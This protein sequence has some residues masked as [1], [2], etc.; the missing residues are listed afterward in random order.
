MITKYQPIQYNV[1]SYQ[2][3]SWPTQNKYFQPN[4]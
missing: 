2:K 4:E 3:H 1:V